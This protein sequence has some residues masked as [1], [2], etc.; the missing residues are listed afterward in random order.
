[1][2]STGE[3]FWSPNGVDGYHTYLQRA[4][5]KETFVTFR[6][7]YIRNIAYAFQYLEYLDMTMAGALHSTVQSQTRKTFIITGCGIIESILWMLLKAGDYQKKDWWEEVQ[8]RQTNEF[9]DDGQKLKFEV[10]QYCKRSS[11]VEL[12]MRFIDMCRR[13]EN[14]KVLGITSDVYAQ[15][16]HLRELRNRVHIHAVQHDR[17]NDWWI[18]EAR[19]VETM[20]KVL[21]AVLRTDI[22]APF[23]LYDVNFEWLGT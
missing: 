2:A 1:M 9:D 21:R 20:K 3:G 5:P 18:F 4:L 23:P 10:R 13:A 14:M 17:D 22:F 6:R 11:P 12:E 15:I 7:A 8:K 19:D 16:G